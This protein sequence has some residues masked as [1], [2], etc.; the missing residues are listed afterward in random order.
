MKYKLILLNDSFGFET[1]SKKKFQIDVY[2]EFSADFLGIAQLWRRISQP[3]LIFYRFSLVF[4]NDRE[5]LRLN[6]NIL[7]G[8]KYRVLL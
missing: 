4:P 1:F 7:D 6:N 2:F 3:R 5:V 8:K